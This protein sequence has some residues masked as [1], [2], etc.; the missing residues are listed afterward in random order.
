MVLVQFAISPELR[1][2]LLK[3]ARCRTGSGSDGAKQVSL[4]AKLT[5][6][7]QVPAIEQAQDP[8]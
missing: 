4:G 2:L 7:D 1:A 6:A 3:S 5:I 8:P